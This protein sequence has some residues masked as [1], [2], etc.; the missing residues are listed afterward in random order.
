MA[1]GLSF[2]PISGA[3]A[4]QTID[5]NTT[6]TGP[7]YGNAHNSDGTGSPDQS[8]DNNTVT[9]SSGGDVTG[10]NGYV[11]GGHKES[12]ST[13]ITVNN[14]TITIISGGKVNVSVFG[15]YAN[16]VSGPGDATAI[17]NTVIISGGSVGG[18]GGGDDD[19]IGGYAYSASGTATVTDNMV[20]FSGG[21]SV[22]GDVLGGYADSSSGTG[23]AKAS[24]NTVNISGGDVAGDVFGGGAM[25]A[26]GDVTATYNTVNIS[27][28]S[29]GG[30]VHGGAAMSASGDVTATYNTV[31]ISGGSVGGNVYGGIVFSDSNGDFFTGNTLNLKADNMLTVGGIANFQYLN[32]YL[33]TTFADGDTMLTVTGTADIDNSIVNVGIAG[34][35]SALAKGDTV[36]LIS[37]STLTGVL[38]NTTADGHGMQGVTLKYEFD[39]WA[40]TDVNKL[41]ARVIS[42]GVNEQAKAIPEGHLA[43]TA[44]LLGGADL[45]A[46]Q[47]LQA[48]RNAS[49]APGLH[50]FGTVSGEHLRYNTGSHVDVSGYHLIAGFTAGGEL[51]NAHATLGAFFEYGEG[52]YDTHNSFAAAARVKG[53]GDA[54]YAGVGVL[55]RL[56]FTGTD[57]GHPYL[58]ATLRSGRVSSDFHSSDL[59][60]N[61]DRRASFE[62]KATYYGASIGAGYLWQVSEQTT[63]DLYGH[64]LWTHENSDSVRLKYTGDPVKFAAIDS[65]RV[66]LGA[67]YTHAINTS[68]NAHVGLA[69]E[70]EFDGEAKAKTNDYKIEAPKLKGNSGIVELGLTLN[71][72]NNI[73]LTLDF[74]IQGYAGK[75]EGATV[76][77][78]VNYKF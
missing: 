48:A 70:H 42:A 11:H 1:L 28:G 67:T 9:V 14:N 76:S 69:W 75:R 78:R 61:Q 26:S 64:Y 45:A 47:G 4:G 8:P 33:P 16:T 25:S 51:A 5:I 40:D 21:S 22:V 2:A 19:V 17:S 68:L 65:Q 58:D 63:F 30:N 13:S 74:G 36:T 72:A 49:L 12:S 18:S 10:T 15:G 73:P 66:K 62:S 77:A 37:A 6:A 34:S 55:G 54:D 3:L 7:I 35:S 39:I 52:D 23:I 60:D 31:N 41:F 59:R 43:G 44:N 29:V 53:K 38:F 57:S 20:N 27:G 56:D 24:S 32:F 46:G 71:P 50:V